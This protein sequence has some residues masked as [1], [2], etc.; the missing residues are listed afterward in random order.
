MHYKPFQFFFLT[1][2]G[3][4]IFWFAAAYLSHQKGVEKWQIF[5]MLAGLLVPCVVALVMIYGSQN[6]AL[7]QSFWERLLLFKISG[8]SLLVIAAI[9]IVFFCATAISLLFGKSAEQFHLASEFNVMKGWKLLSL[10]VPLLL[11]PALEEMG[12]R[13]YGIDSLR[14][15]FNVFSTSM[16]FGLLWA[17]WHVPLFFI[18]GYYQYELWQSSI[19]YTAN[20]FISI[21]PVAIITNWVYFQNGRSILLLILVHGLLNACAILFKVEQFTKCI[22]TVLLCLFAGILVACER[23]FFLSR[24]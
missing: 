8:R 17:L 16:L 6:S 22:A 24:P 21:I 7:I 15:N 20:F 11:A 23:D 9:P 4:S 19:V 18:K 10:I 2:L 13:G 5:P 3:T 1:L 12:W 14:A